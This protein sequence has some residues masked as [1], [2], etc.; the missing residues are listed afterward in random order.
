MN[1]KQWVLVDTETTGLTAPVFVVE[2]GAQR[3]HG[4]LPEGPP[5]R[6]LLN[7][8]MDIPPASARIHGYTREILERDGDAAA[9]VYR[10]FAAYAGGLPLVAFNLEYDLDEVLLPEWKRLSITPMVSAGFC[11]LRLA[12]R[13]LDPVPAGNCKLQTLRQYYRLPERGAHTALG[14]VE[15]VADLLANV[16]R[17]IAEQRQLSSWADICA[18]TKAEWFPSRIAFGKFKG[19][20][21]QDA[22]TDS[23]LLGWLQW[24]ANSANTRSAS[25]GRWYLEQLE[26]GDVQ[27]ETLFTFKVTAA[28]NGDMPPAAG[29]ACPPAG[30]V[31]F[32]NPEIGPLRQLIAAARTQLADL[33]AAYMQDRC[34]I[35]LMQ[36]AIFN[37]VRGHY[38]Q[39]DRLKLII[40]YRSL[41]LKTLLRSG[42][43]EA[44]QVSEDYAQARA[45]S[46]THYEQAQAAAAKRKAMSRVEEAELKTLWKKLVRLYHPDRFAHQPDKL[47]TY[48]HLTSAI[49]QARENGDMAR[50]REIA[51]DPH[52][53]ILRQGWVSLDFGDEAVLKN[54]QRLFDTLQ[55]EIV[56]TMESRNA[57]HDSAEFELHRLC[58][59]TPGLLEDVA[60]GQI[61]VIATEIAELK[62]QAVQ[63]ETDIAEL[64][65]DPETLI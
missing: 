1:N 49:N 13:L 19:R 44:A 23:A 53:F 37:L 20:Q 2:L 10:D 18:Y 12:Q 63:L 22:R 61:K 25:M 62:V 4:W 50:L 47:E 42:E 39:R 55:L 58:A 5:F 33:E 3:M 7:Q 17:P 48:N 65:C 56:T 26:R 32:V 34:A 52:A 54:L 8:N 24:L 15:T 6:R 64:T 21:I 30:L 51:D 35:D 59:Q 57:L 16:L 45:Q 38:Q 40:N 14:D 46:D 29:S 31:V 28:T 60:A 36:A 41:Y 9:V 27:S 11:A 43:D